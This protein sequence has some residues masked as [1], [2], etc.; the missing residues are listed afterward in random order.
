MSGSLTLHRSVAAAESVLRYQRPCACLVQTH[1]S[2]APTWSHLSS[3]SEVSTLA[4]EFSYLSTMTGAH[5]CRAVP[6]C[7]LRLMHRVGTRSHAWRV[8]LCCHAQGVVTLP[9]YKWGMQPTNRA[10]THIRSREVVP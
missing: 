10:T 6:L 9:V 5:L 2:A 4:M 7:R 1:A 3:L 8:Q